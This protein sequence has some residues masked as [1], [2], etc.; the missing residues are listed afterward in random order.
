MPIEANTPRYKRRFPGRP[1]AMLSWPVGRADAGRGGQP[2]VARTPGL[3]IDF[4]GGTPAAPCSGIVNDFSELTSVPGGVPDIISALRE[5][6]CLGDFAIRRVGGVD[7]KMG[8]DL[9]DR[10]RGNLKAAAKAAL[11]NML[12]GGVDQTP[13]RTVLTSG[14]TFIAVWS[15]FLF[16]SEVLRG[17]SYALIVGVLVESYF[18]LRG[19]PVSVVAAGRG[20]GAHAPG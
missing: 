4:K 15:L 13:S 18:H 1:Q 16:G 11:G 17:C 7:R 2:G 14:L 8:R 10:V 3:E 12:I 9:F 5:E 19:Q 6:A 20:D